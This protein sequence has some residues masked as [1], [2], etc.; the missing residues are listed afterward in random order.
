MTEKKK[1]LLIT[2]GTGFIG[3][4]LVEKLYELGY[5][6]RLFVRDTSN[7]APFKDF[8]GVEY[9]IGDITNLGDI[10]RASEDIDVIFHLA[11][12]TGIWAEN[13]SIYDEINVKGTKNIAQVALEK[14]I[15]LLYVS[16]FTA[17][18]PTP[19]E[20]VDENYEKTGKFY[21]EYE[22][23]KY[24]A[25][26]IIEDYFEKGLNGIMFYPG[27]VY[28]PGDFNIFGEMLYDI[29]RGKF[30]GCPG[31][32]ES[33]ACFSYVDDVVDAMIKVLEREDINREDFILGGENIE[34][35]KYL[36]MIA[37]IADKKEPR[38]FPMVF[39][40]AYGWICE[41]GAKITKNTPYIT[42]DTL[43]SFELDRAYS[44]EKA[45][46]TFDYDITPLKEGLKNTIE[47]Y[48]DFIEKDKGSKQEVLTAEELAKER[49]NIKI[50]N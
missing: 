31:N 27:I 49:D 34:F 39:A 47:W 24:E 20:P 12:Y 17:L 26:K 38:H 50:I 9:F 21:L 32:G 22:R 7:I 36:D 2:G 6:L 10:K 37:D 35:V 8:K 42:R 4:A 18:G 16:S 28:G 46:E 19:E 5:D 15:R 30:L 3:K 1:R 44:S 23:T 14:D 40:K 48:Q 11:A 29:V 45:I 41:L 33:M 43:D 25:K 13:K